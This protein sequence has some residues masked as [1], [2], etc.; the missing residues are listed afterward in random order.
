[1]GQ[2][3]HAGAGSHPAG[4]CGPRR[5]RPGG[6]PTRGPTT[7]RGGGC[8]AGCG[9]TPGCSTHDRL[10]A[11]GDRSERPDTRRGP[12]HADSRPG[13]FERAPG[14]N[15]SKAGPRSGASSA[16]PARRAYSWTGTPRYAPARPGP[17]GV[18]RTAV[19]RA[20]PK[21]LPG[22]SRQRISPA[23]GPALIQP[24]GWAPAPG[25]HLPLSGW[26]RAVPARRHGERPDH[27]TRQRR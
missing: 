6:R 17:D 9:P 15:G 5:F 23:P 19:R 22:A 21:R 20:A 18:V 7:I 1:V 26:G 2:R 3:V 12:V 13:R 14:R 4:G 16:P 8:A 25:S 24:K 11:P 27:R 10:P